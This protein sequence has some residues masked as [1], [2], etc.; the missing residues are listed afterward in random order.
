MGTT[1]HQLHLPFEGIRHFFDLASWPPKRKTELRIRKVNNR[2]MSPA[3]C[4][5]RTLEVFGVSLEEE[6]R[7]IY[8]PASNA[9][10]QSSVP[11]AIEDDIRMFL[12]RFFSFV[13]R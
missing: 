13:F 5:E 7:F 6:N 11:N 9:R 1:L 2:Q 4:S 10:R 8:R 12:S 3:E